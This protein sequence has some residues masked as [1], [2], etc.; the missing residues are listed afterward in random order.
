MTEDTYK[1]IAIIMQSAY[2]VFIFE[3]SCIWNRDI[4]YNNMFMVIHL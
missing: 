4:L 2:T 3:L 1:Y